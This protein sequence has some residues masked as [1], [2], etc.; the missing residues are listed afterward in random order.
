MSLLISKTTEDLIIFPATDITTP[1]IIQEQPVAT[2]IDGGQKTEENDNSVDLTKID[3]LS[4]LSDSNIGKYLCRPTLIANLTWTYGGAVNT[5]IEP[6]FDFLNNSFVASK[7]ANYHLIRGKMKIRVLLNGNKFHMGRLSVGWYPNETLGLLSEFT[8]D[9]RRNTMVPG[10]R[11]KPLAPNK[12]ETFEMTIPF[13]YPYPYIS[14]SDYNNTD[15]SVGDIRIMSLTPLTTSNAVVVNANIAVY[16]WLEE[17]YELL[18]PRPVSQKSKPIAISSQENEQ[19][20]NGL[21][22][23]VTSAFA[24]AAGELTQLPVIGPMAE[25]GQNILNK[26]T[27]VARIFGFSRPNIITDPMYVKN[28]PFSSISNTSGNETVS[29]LSFDPK[30]SIS[31]ELSLVGLS[32]IDQMAIKAISEEWSLWYTVPWL[33]T[34]VFNTTITE[35]LVTPG[36]ISR[37]ALTKLSLQTRVAYASYPFEYWSGGLEYKFVITSTVF[38]SGRL[39]L[40]Y[41]PYG[42]VHAVANSNS[43]YMQYFDLT[44]T[45]EFTVVVPWM[46]SEPY[47]LTGGNLT[48]EFHDPVAVIY[49]SAISNGSLRLSVVNPLVAP[50]PA[51]NVEI[52]VFVRAHP[53]FEVFVPSTSISNS[54]TPFPASEVVVFGSNKPESEISAK[55][56]VYF[57]EKEVSFRSL[58]KRYMIHHA[59]N[60]A[61]VNGDFSAIYKYDQGAFPYPNT[62]NLLAGNFSWA[63]GSNPV[64]N[65]LLSYLRFSY[66]GWRGSIRWKFT[67]TPAPSPAVIGTIKATR[68]P[69]QLGVGGTFSPLLNSTLT[70]AAS[71]VCNNVSAFGNDWLGSALTHFDNMPSLEY[72]VPFY[73]NARYCQT[74]INSMMPSL[75]N[76]FCNEDTL[77]SSVRMHVTMKDGSDADL[78]VTTSYVAAGDDFQFLYFIAP[79]IWRTYA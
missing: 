68:D 69:N 25:T 13:F 12:S 31:N 52:L 37:V 55:P 56:L 51:G 30:Q 44:E 65:T 4:N 20:P 66:A 70:F 28:Q 27:R 49:N 26:I 57:G 9:S 15:R 3:R 63:A 7:V 50:D 73:N 40:S 41:D 2:F 24:S 77:A 62:D 59:N 46:Q 79:P 47:K 29:K 67:S 48:N 16:A 72:E 35:M 1:L 19:E 53:S 39:A 36:M 14:I 11:D 21:I 76:D 8:L 38:H 23:N 45:D 10:T 61:L 32:P 64:N 34:D 22:S 75:T 6:W 5:F 78:L 54:F 71:S 58:L 17:D 42:A 74:G 43:Q 60:T 18:V 33:T